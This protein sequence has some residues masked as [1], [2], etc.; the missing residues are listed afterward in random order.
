MTR[1][2][3]SLARETLRILKPFWW[4]VALSTVLGIVSGLSVTGLLATINNALNMPGGPD[5]H[6]ALLF[7]GLCVLTLACATLSNLS[8]NYVASA[9]SPICVASWPPRCWSRPSSNWSATAPTV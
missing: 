2:T 4:L 1:K 6:T 5:T 8:T 9:W 3:E 7:A